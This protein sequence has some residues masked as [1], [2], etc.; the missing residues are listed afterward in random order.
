MRVC[1][2]FNTKGFRKDQKNA[3]RK[4][5]EGLKK[6]RGILMETDESL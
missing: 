1:A 6:V 4:P 5:K 3:Q 2:K